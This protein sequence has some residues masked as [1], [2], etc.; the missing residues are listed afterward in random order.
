MS[1]EL[2]MTWKRAEAQP[3]TDH[4]EISSEARQRTRRRENRALIL[5]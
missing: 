2:P 5:I 4:A 1:T 3:L